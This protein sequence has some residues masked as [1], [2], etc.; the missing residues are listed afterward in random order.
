RVVSSEVKRSRISRLNSAARG[1]TTAE[2]PAAKKRKIRVLSFI[3]SSRGK[4]G[5]SGRSKA[6]PAAVVARAGSNAGVEGDQRGEPRPGAGGHVSAHLPAGTRVE[7]PAPMNGRILVVDDEP[8]IRDL[9]KWELGERGFEV[10]E[11]ADGQR[12]VEALGKASFDVVI[13][14]VR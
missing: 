5:C 11:A 3:G 7:P 9:A 12:A 8:G 4:R 6:E 2:I 14:D 10:S 13:S 1:S